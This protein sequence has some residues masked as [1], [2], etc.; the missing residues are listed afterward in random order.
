MVDVEHEAEDVA[1]IDKTDDDDVPGVGRLVGE[2]RLEDARP[3]ELADGAFLGT[4]G[5]L[6]APRRVGQRPEIAVVMLQNIQLDQAVEGVVNDRLRL[7]GKPFD[8]VHGVPLKGLPGDFLQDG[9]EHRIAC[10]RRV[11]EDQRIEIGVN[12]REQGE[13]REHRAH[14]RAVQIPAGDLV[15]NSRSSR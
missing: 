8:P 11:G 9:I 14:H 15:E 10:L 13:F 7:A 1:R 6:L 3:Y 12:A 2:E 5:I 4:P